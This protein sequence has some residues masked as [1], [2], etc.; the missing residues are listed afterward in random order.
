MKGNAAALVPGVAGTGSWLIGTKDKKC[1][2]F[3]ASGD[4]STHYKEDN[5]VE[6]SL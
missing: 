4:H 6:R 3:A 1:A 2:W 5:N